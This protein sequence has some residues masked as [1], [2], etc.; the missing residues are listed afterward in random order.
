[1]GLLYDKMRE[2]CILQEEKLTYLFTLYSRI[3]I[4]LGKESFNPKNGVSQGGINS[5]ILFNFAMYYFLTEAAN[6]IK[7]LWLARND[8]KLIKDAEDRLD[9]VV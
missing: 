4:E 9:V 8:M 6:K 5:P 2:D 3:R 7:E 1:M